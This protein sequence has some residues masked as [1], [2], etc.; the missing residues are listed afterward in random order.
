MSQI[1]WLTQELWFPNVNQALTDPDGLLAAGG[2]LSIDRLLLAYSKGIFPWYSDGQPILWWSPHP[3]CL[4]D[5]EHLHISRSLKKALN[6]HTF[7]ISFN[8]AFGS[9]IENCAKPREYSDETWIL[10]EMVN[11]YRDLHDHGHAHSIEVWQMVDKKEMLV[12]GLY[13]VSIGSC[14]FGESMFSRV[15]NASKIAFV[16]LVNQLTEWGYNLI[17]CQLENDHL[18]S[19]G[20]Y[21]VGKEDFLAI[22]N[23]NVI[24][25]R[26]NDNW[27]LT[28]NWSK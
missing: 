24:K 26:P 25:K 18:T 11:A 21:L 9:V 22:L 8:E 19:L 2:D 6:K 23:E 7:R 27:D 13:G 14:F 20:A 5:L 4:I 16:Y 1:P 10:P 12:G 3:R 17:D 15:T 28:W